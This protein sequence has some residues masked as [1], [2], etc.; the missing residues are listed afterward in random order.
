MRRSTVLE[1]RAPGRVNLIGEHTDYNDG[2]VLPA[3][4]GYDTR[5]RVL[6]REDTLVR[7]T[8]D[9]FRAAS[10]TFD[11]RSLPS[12]RRRDWGDYPRG[13]LL[14]LQ[15]AGVPLCGA[16]L[17]ASATIPLGAGLSSSAS[18]EVA[19]ALAML[20]LASSEMDRLEIAKLAQRAE[21]EHVGT[22]SGIMDQFAALF[23]EVGSAVFLDTRTLH[24]DLVPIPPDVRVVIAN[25]MVKHHHTTGDYNERRLEC[26]QAVEALRRFYPDIRALR[27]VSLD[28]L[29]AN[30]SE[31]PQVLYR[32]ARHVVAENERVIAS[33]EAMKTN[34]AAALGMLMNASHESLRNDFAV[35]C[36]ELDLMT[37]I[38]RNLD[39]CYGARMTGGGF[40]GCTVSLVDAA[41]GEAFQSML[42][43]AYHRETG[44]VPELYDGTPAAGAEIL[45]G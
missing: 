2:Y 40:G 5:V 44:I 35:S 4:I 6:P 43:E 24:Y 19:L 42:G 18:F 13:I 11:L 32:R 21:V 28:M 39:G 31:I 27:D 8:S 30:A 36:D 26:E 1:V 38:A 34:D 23:G 7:V 25:T 12:A 37:T 17:H 10:I 20:A 14:E 41:Y 9:H 3:A 15:R 16:D 22:R 29:E 33:V 45:D